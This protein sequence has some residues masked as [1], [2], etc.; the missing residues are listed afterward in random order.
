MVH[1][2]PTWICFDVVD[3]RLLVTVHASGEGQVEVEPADAD[4]LLHLITVHCTEENEK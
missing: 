1:S 3:G 4:K 2:G